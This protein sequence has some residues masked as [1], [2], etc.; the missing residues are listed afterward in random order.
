M[1]AK[2]SPTCT[3]SICAVCAVDTIDLWTTPTDPL[4]KGQVARERP[5]QRADPGGSLV[6]ANVQHV[7]LAGC[8]MAAATGRTWDGPSFFTCPNGQQ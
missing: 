6:V 3:E 4:S 7:L 2:T 5:H 1:L 8:D